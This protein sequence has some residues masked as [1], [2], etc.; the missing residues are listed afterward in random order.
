MNIALI[1]HAL[2]VIG[3]T[4]RI[5]WRD[6]LSPVARL[7]WFIIILIFP[8]AGVAIYWMFGEVKLG[9]NADSY[10]Q[11]TLARLHNHAPQ[12]LGEAKN[13]AEKI[14]LCYRA[15]FT[16][17]HSVNAFY[18]VGGNRIELMPDAATTRQ[19]MIADMDVATRQ[20]HILYYIWLTDNTGSDIAAALMRAARR[21]VTCRVMAD[22]MGSRQLIKSDL[23]RE[24]ADAGVEL[25]VALP[26]KRLLKTILFSRID[27]RNH[28]KITVIDGKITY[29]GSQNCADPA[30]LLKAKYA[31]WVDIMLRLQGPIVAQNQMLFAGDWLMAKPQT[32]LNEFVFDTQTQDDGSA[33]AAIYADGPTERQ[34]ATPQL[35]ITL[36][37]QAQSEL[38]IS[39]PYFVPDYL[40]LGA[41]CATAHRGV[42]VTLIFPQRNDSF[43]VA[44]T[45]RSY[46]RQLLEAGI[47]IYEYQDGLLHAKTLT[48]DTKL[49]FI[50]STNLDLRS[51]D[52]NYENNVLI[53]DAAVATAIRTRQQSYIDSSKRVA[54]ST[55]NDWSFLRRLWNNIVATI[56]PIL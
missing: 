1:L 20:I 53:Y 30:F 15:G 40:V 48:I 3:L 39:T 12:V 21:G 47:R 36:F 44:A 55:V 2:L 9:F 22:A 56:G 43:V 54:L 42:K 29:C 51:F 18:P 32:P 37:T 31:P 33:V 27:L 17:L 45:S 23:W 5:L 28:R 49:A 38:I 7:A 10:A 16:Y 19:Q 6:D 14:S 8:Y 41:L 25:V 46:Y 26:F 13:I 52:L 11:Q 50:G 24:M 4:L 34:A 35:F